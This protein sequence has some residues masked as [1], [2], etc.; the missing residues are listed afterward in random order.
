MRTTAGAGTAGCVAALAALLA[1]CAD[2]AT[3]PDPQRIADSAVHSDPQPTATS[4]I[5]SAAPSTAPGVDGKADPDRVFT[6]ADLKA[7]LLPAKAF[8]E[9][10]RETGTFLGGFDRGYG[11]GDWSG[12]A[13]AR[14]LREEQF[15]FRGTSAT[16]SVSLAP[17]SEDGEH[18][19]VTLVSIPT[20]RAERYLEIRRQLNKTCPDVTVDTDA[21]PVQEIHEA[22]GLPALGDEALLEISRR[23]GSDVGYDDAAPS[24]TVDVRVGGVL[25]MVDTSTGS[26]P[27]DSVSFAANVARR[28]RSALYRTDG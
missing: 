8:G 26:D 21:A 4:D 24:C 25:V 15:A 3:R 17:G 13:A 23:T 9:R 6:E 18:V 11:R 12:C 2:P 7:A 20:G 14:D 10:A 5:P 27:D 1:G 28:V 16:R 22:R 19:T